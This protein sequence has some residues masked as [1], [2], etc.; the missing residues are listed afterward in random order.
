[1]MKLDHLQKSSTKIN[2]KNNQQNI[3]VLMTE[4]FKV[5]NGLTVII[6]D[7][8]FDP[9]VNFPNLRNFQEFS[10]ERKKLSSHA[11]KL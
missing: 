2:G 5:M 1:M 7:N 10:A 11:W 8:I 9:R 6:I 4:V 3:Q